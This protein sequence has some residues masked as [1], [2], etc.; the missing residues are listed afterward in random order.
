MQKI[1]GCVEIADNP[2]E[3]TVDAV[4]L[5][6]IKSG[7]GRAVAFRHP[8]NQLRHFVIGGSQSDT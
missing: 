3:N 1:R 8:L 4:G 5:E 2:E 7:Q 6:L